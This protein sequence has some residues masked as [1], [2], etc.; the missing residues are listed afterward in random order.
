VGALFDAYAIWDGGSTATLALSTLS[1][2]RPGLRKVLD[3]EMQAP[4]AIDG[5][6]ECFVT[7]AHAF[8]LWILQ[9]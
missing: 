1:P 5:L 4:V 8:I 7:N 2:F 9:G 6:I 3:E